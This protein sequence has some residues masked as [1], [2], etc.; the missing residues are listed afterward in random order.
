M[1]CLTADHYIADVEAFRHILRS[2]F[3]LASEAILVTLGITADVSSHRVW[4]HPA[5]EPR[6]EF[7]GLPGY[8][9]LAFKEKPDWK[10][11]AAIWPAVSIPGT[12]GCLSGKS[13]RSSR[14][15]TG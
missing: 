14:R 10:R 4:L 7:E 3:T 2:A 12:R 15:S 5:G 6:G 8:R 9:V 13:K 1:A 11:P